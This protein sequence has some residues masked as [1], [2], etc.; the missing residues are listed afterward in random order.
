MTPSIRPALLAAAVAAALLALAHH[1]QAGKTYDTVAG[2]NT[3]TTRM[4][5]PVTRDHRGQPRPVER[6]RYPCRKLP[7]KGRGSSCIYR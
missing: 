5:D 4:P 3:G 1:A 6:S 7:F 2:I